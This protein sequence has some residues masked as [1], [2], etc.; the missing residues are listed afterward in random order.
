MINLTNKNTI[1]LWSLNFFS[2]SRT[3]P[4]RLLFAHTYKI[5]RQ[6]EFFAATASIL[7][8]PWTNQIQP[9]SAENILKYVSAHTPRP[10]GPKTI[11]RT[12]ESRFDLKIEVCEDK[13][14]VDGVGSREEAFHWGCQ[15]LNFS[16]MVTFWHLY[17]RVVCSNYGL[18]TQTL[19]FTQYIFLQ[20]KNNFVKGMPI[21]KVFQLSNGDFSFGA[22][23]QHLQSALT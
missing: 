5:L 6:N 10:K 11:I 22:C 18:P 9:G 16:K 4:G 15:P 19:S 7:D 17:F 14:K 8:K 1:F 12:L 20:V 21:L 2:R 23:L 3:D 13:L